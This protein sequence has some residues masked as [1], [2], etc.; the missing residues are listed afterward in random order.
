MLK[1]I[2]K[3]AFLFKTRNKEYFLQKSLVL[4]FKNKQL[5]F[6]PQLSPSHSRSRLFWK[7]WQHRKFDISYDVVMLSRRCLKTKDELYVKKENREN[8]IC[9][10]SLSNWTVNLWQYFIFLECVTLY[11]T[12]YFI[13]RSLFGM[14]SVN[15]KPSWFT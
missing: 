10:I 11:V 14:L 13:Y 3:R 1:I 2:N 4:V 5:L 9:H 8:N 12:R 6:R 15:K 7:W